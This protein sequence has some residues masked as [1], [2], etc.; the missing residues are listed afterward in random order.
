MSVYK[1]IILLNAFTKIYAMAGL[2]LGYALCS[3]SNIARQMEF[4]QSE[5]NVSS[6]AQVSGL[7]A[8]SQEKYLEKTI[9]VIER[10]RRF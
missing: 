5:W 8:L 10:E 2:R 7:V 6:L 9:R 4:L 3:D 1:N